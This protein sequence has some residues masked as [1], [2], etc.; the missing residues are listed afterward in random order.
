[1]KAF[2]AT[3]KSEIADVASVILHDKVGNWFLQ[4]VSEL[5]IGLKICRI[6]APLS[7]PGLNYQMA[8]GVLCSSLTVDNLESRNSH[9]VNKTN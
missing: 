6:E 8:C 7:T 1:M 4:V 3:P 2:G 5:L 9:C